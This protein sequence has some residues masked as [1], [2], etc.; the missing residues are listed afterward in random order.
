MEEKINAGSSQQRVTYSELGK[1][2]YQ[3]IECW[4]T[5]LTM[6][7]VDYQIHNVANNF[8]SNM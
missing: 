7:N 5:L 8:Q 4:A 1:Q 6:C 2:L 3:L